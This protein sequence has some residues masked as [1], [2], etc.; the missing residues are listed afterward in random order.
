MIDYQVK[1]AFDKVYRENGS[2][3]TALGRHLLEVEAFQDA[4]RKLDITDCMDIRDCVQ[5]LT[6]K[7]KMKNFGEISALELLAKLGLFFNGVQKKEN[8]VSM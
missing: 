4:A 6:E 8:V 3:E 7:K 1:T 5:T 2:P